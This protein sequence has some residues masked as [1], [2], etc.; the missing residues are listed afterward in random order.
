MARRA[1]KKV[2][3]TADYS[4][5]NVDFSV[6]DKILIT[7]FCGSLSSDSA[8]RVRD[9]V[10]CGFKMSISYDSRNEAFTLSLT[11]KRK[12]SGRAKFPVYMIHHADC[13]KLLS[14]GFWFWKEAL[15]GGDTEL[16]SDADKY[17]W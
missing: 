15:N 7:D 6:E 14:I 10:E 11:D 12:V 8:S 9:I 16:G 13:E 2:D 3:F 4:V 17:D 1:T 5:I